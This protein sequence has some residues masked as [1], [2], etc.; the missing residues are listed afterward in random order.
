VVA[1]MHE[2]DSYLVACE[3]TTGEIAWKV[4]RNYPANTESQ[5]SYATP[6]VIKEN[7]KSVLVVWGANRLSGHEA[8]TGKIIWVC[9][10]FNPRDKRFWRT[11]ASPAL[12]QG[13]AVVPYGRGDYLAGIKM[14][15]SGDITSTARLWEKDDLGADVSTPVAIGDLV[16]GVSFKGKAWC[17]NIH[18]GKELWETK[19][20]KGRG[21]F[22]SSPVLAGNKLYICREKG[23]FYV[24]EVSS[25]GI[26][27]LNQV[28]FEDHLAAT[29]V[30]MN[31]KI[32]LRGEKN[33]YCIGK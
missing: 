24:C 28:K 17:V 33:L 1:V 20:P 16:Y 19:L 11:I 15:G 6:H 30:L 22:Y 2:Q 8:E 3:Q 32:L 27:V 29:P 4:D 7:G 21:M 18:S 12:S 14:S 10:G 13:I 5:Q 31:N 25:N 9:A 23:D 26:E